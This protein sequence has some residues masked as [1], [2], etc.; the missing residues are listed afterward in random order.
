MSNTTKPRTYIPRE[1][2]EIFRVSEEKVLR[3]IASGEL[4][5]FNVAASTSGRPRWR[6]T[7]EALDDFIRT[8]SATP[9]PQK[10]TR[11]KRQRA[12]VQQWY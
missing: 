6:I 5:A 8:R 7:Q 1:V 10:P 12:E 2:A 9:P 3:W 11:R 4:V